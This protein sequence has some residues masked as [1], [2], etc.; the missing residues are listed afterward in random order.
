MTPGAAYLFKGLQKRGAKES[1]E[2]IAECTC[3][4][5]SPVG[6]LVSE[7][8]ATLYEGRHKRGNVAFFDHGGLLFLPSDPAWIEMRTAAGD[9][10]AVAGAAE[11]DGSIGIVTYNMNDR[12]KTYQILLRLRVD[13]EFTIEFE[14]EAYE[15]IATTA[16]ATTAM[17]TCAMWISA[18]LMLINA[19]RGVERRSIPS[20]KGRQ[21]E[22]HRLGLG[23]MRPA[24]TI[25]LS[26]RSENI[27]GGSGRG[28]PKCFHYARAHLRRLQTGVTVKVRGCWK[29]DPSLGIN[30]RPDYKVMD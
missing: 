20:H 16:M 25:Y 19:P 26:R 2:F 14:N 18:S 10:G 11:E 12:Q 27:S 21:R 17:A 5:L 13:D 8:M 3:F 7:T 22:F 29:G 1:A 23:V 24:H 15:S 30:P 9:F 4:D 6:S 28:S